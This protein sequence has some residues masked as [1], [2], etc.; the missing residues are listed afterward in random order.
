MF[1]T[2]Q[3]PVNV[4][5]HSLIT[6]H[7]CL[8]CIHGHTLVCTY[9]DCE[10]VCCA[11]REYHYT[12]YARVHMCALGEVNQTQRRDF[13]SKCTPCGSHLLHSNRPART[14]EKIEYGSTLYN[15][16]TNRYHRL[17]HTTY[18]VHGIC[19]CKASQTL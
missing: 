9:T 4:C 7:S 16:H 18:N 15:A 8:T 1:S 10:S 13:V 14:Q 2:H 17:L 5:S 12:G 3:L 6:L 11:V 19:F